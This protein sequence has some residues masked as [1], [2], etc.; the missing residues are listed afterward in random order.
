VLDN[1]S[2]D[3]SDDMVAR[4]FPAVRLVRSDLNLGFA[5]GTNAL[6]ASSDADYL[7]PLNSD[8][9]WR[10][11][12]ATP[13]VGEL[14]RDPAIAVV[15]PRLV[16]P[17]GRRQ[18]SCQ[19]IPGMR[20]EL[21]MQLRGTRLTRMP[22]G[23][24]DADTIIRD[25]RGEDLDDMSAPRDA[26]FLWA[27]CWVL[28]RRDL[29]GRIFDESFAMYDEDLDFCVRMRRAGRRLVYVPG[30]ELVHLG[31]AS[32]LPAAK[33]ALMRRA[34]RRFHR[35]HGGPFAEGAYV[36]LTSAPAAVKALNRRRRA[37]TT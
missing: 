20:F 24:W 10:S 27:T 34:R 33:L 31:G 37:L 1:A 11:D 7:M 29:A 32:S 8:T 26:E 12:I 21:A 18:L 28:R 25:F 23:L 17:D 14:E 30:V 9:V 35:R 6:A 15:G 22:F 16:W 5:R 36:L 2:G 19:R 3:G 4:E 13:L